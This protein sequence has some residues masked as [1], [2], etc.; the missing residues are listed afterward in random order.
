MTASP[1]IPARRR[2]FKIVVGII[3]LASIVAIGWFTQQ[4]WR[5]L[6]TAAVHPL[7]VAK[8]ADGHGNAAGHEGH[9]HGSHAGHDHGSTGASE[10][11]T[12]SEQARRNLGLQVAAIEPQDF[13]KRIVVPGQ[14]VNLPG[15]SERRVNA[16][17]Q[18]TILKVHVL[19]GQTVRSG[20][21]L[22]EVQVTSELLASAQSNLL[23]I[24]QDIELN[25][26]E[27]KRLSPIGETGAVSQKLILEKQ[28]EKRRLESARQV[29]L[30][31]LMVRGLSPAQVKTIIE[32]KSLI[33]QFT[34]KVPVIPTGADDANKEPTK[35]IN[36]VQRSRIQQV[37]AKAESDA[38]D[39]TVFI[40]EKLDVFPG[41]LTNPGDELCD[42]ALHSVLQLQGE[43]F[44]TESAQIYRAITERWPVTA[45]FELGDREPLTK[46]KLEIL[47]A[48]SV[49]DPQS[50]SFEFYLPLIND[51]IRDQTGPDGRSFRSW[52]FKPGQQ[53]QLLVPIEKW[54]DR[55]VVPAE[56]VVSEGADSF[57]FKVNGKLL[58][59]Q[60]VV[61]EY[62]D[63]RQAVLANDGSLFPG[64]ELAMNQAYAINLALKK[65]SGSG[66]DLHAGH[67]H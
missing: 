30:Q 28:Y 60:A 24:L 32:E 27:I 25:E 29:Q 51:V 58:Q 64:D 10:T 5:P 19:Q 12:I 2:S 61:I 67:N 44:E 13:W 9:D 42:L 15:R 50:R 26:A 20:D 11:I 65:A 6:V 57:V 39:E 59:R 47:Y 31:E 33:R 63:S 3:L 18:G 40:V 43:A 66:V 34:V 36:L 41:K 16:T 7:P 48:S 37:V 17:V 4:T 62:R 23:R 14:V 56:A 1:P 54:T 46:D 52:R 35:A 8:P 21:A 22:F 53:V 38:A 49:T 55:F 45:V